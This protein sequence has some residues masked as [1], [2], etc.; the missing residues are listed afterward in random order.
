MK[1]RTILAVLM[2]LGVV[3]TFAQQN[4]PKRNTTN[5][6]QDAPQGQTVGSGTGSSAGLMTKYSLG[7]ECSMYM[8]ENFQKGILTL[9][10]NTVFDDRLYRF[11]IYN[12]QM[13]FIL[14][15]DTAAIGNPKEI[16]LLQFD[17]KDFIF[18]EY[19]YDQKM[20]KGYMALLV[21]GDYRLL[22]QCYIKYTLRENADDPNVKP[23]KKYYQEKR[24]FIAYKDEPA[25]QILLKKKDVLN[26]IQ[27]PGKNLEEYMKKT[28]N[29]MKSES[30]LVDVLKYCNTP[31]D[32]KN[33]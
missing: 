15:G 3:V 27:I 5:V 16:R 20:N 21:D 33:Q 23:E 4:A 28:N 2:C 31:L 30:D 19:N 17:E 18:T 24:Y 13:E 9:K 29:H 25:N 6:N 7:E 12:Q 10:D 22:L 8:N 26:S 32:R 11:N 1:S 14:N